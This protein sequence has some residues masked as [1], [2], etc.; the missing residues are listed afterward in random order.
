MASNPAGDGGPAA[1]GAR[2]LA[3]A[4]R[5]V[6]IADA[7]TS[8]PA[9]LDPRC[10]AQ[11][12]QSREAPNAGE[13]STEQKKHVNVVV[14]GHVDSGKSTTTGHLIYKSGGIDTQVLERLET[15]TTKL[16]KSSCKYAWVL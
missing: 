6:T 16:G 13:P 3:T 10:W 7:A 11:C 14:I 9:V 15:E 1:L 5:H 12:S 8:P 2:R 4:A